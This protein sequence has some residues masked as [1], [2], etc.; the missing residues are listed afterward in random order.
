MDLTVLKKKIS[1]FRSEGG[2]LRNV[3]NEVLAEIYAITGEEK[4]LIMSR[5]FHHKAILDP[6]AAGE[7][8]LPGKH[9][10]TQIPKLIGLARRYELTGVESDRQ[11]A[12]LLIDRLLDNQ[13]IR[14]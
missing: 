2:K 6:L 13:N 14:V 11:A 1:T 9:G 5:K 12:E 3:S 4:Y 8:I 10:N 7:D